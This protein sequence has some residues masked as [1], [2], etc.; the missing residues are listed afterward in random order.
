MRLIDADELLKNEFKNDISFNAFKNLVKRQK[1]ID[2][3]SVVRCKDCK[4]RYKMAC[5]EAEFYECSHIGLTS[6]TGKI[7]HVGVTDDYFCADGERRE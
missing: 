1:T 5:H 3:V 6:K 2:A 4:H 7:T